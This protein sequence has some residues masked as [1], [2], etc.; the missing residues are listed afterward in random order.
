MKILKLFVQLPDREVKISEDVYNY[1]D[2]DIRQDEKLYLNR[3][4]FIEYSLYVSNSSILSELDYLSR[5]LL[6]FWLE[7][8][9]D[10]SG[11]DIPMIIV[12]RISKVVQKIYSCYSPEHKYWIIML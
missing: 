10:I 2:E 3:L 7:N 12:D 9:D 1:F 5:Q 11:A 8:L 6:V 4:K